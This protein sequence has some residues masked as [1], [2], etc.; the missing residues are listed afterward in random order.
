MNPNNPVPGEEPETTKA[1]VEKKASTIIDVT[2]RQDSFEQRILA[3]LEALRQD[4]Q[5][6]RAEAVRSAPLPAAKPHQS[7]D[8]INR[9]LN[10]PPPRK[11]GDLG[12]GQYFAIASFRY[13]QVIEHPRRVMN[14]ATKLVE[15]TPVVFVQ[16]RQ[17]HGPGSE[18]IDEKTGAP[19]FRWGVLD[20]AEL[21]AVKSGVL[22]LKVVCARLEETTDFAIG[23]VIS[24][25]TAQRFLRAKY[26]QLRYEQQSRAALENRLS[27]LAPGAEKSGILAVA[28]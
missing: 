24:F 13:A 23:D 5:R 3:E 27:G 6:L 2:K 28:Q 7:D 17:Y 22:D 15:E 1:A 8:E 11:K 4:N 18:L 9:F 25:E 16:A 26:E 10:A 14:D 19:M 12:Y 20:L 21:P